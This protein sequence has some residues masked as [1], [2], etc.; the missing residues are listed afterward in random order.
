M[1][2][3]N[4]VQIIGRLGQNPEGRQLPNGNTV[5]NLSVATS[6]TWKDKDTGERKERTEW[7]RVTIYGKLA[8]VAVQYLE[9]GSQ[10]FL[11]GRLQT[12]KWED[13][14]GVTR[15]TTEI[16]ADQ[17][18]MLAR[19]PNSA[20][21]DRR[22]GGEQRQQRSQAQ[23]RQQSGAPADTGSSQSQRDPDWDDDIPF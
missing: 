18:V 5:A 15:Y 7:H 3:L 14:E 9:K 6:E 19:A 17:L 20:G 13:K 11:Q 16:V 4:Q 1:S 12:R 2:S 22:N 21:G 10:A 23:G 8:D